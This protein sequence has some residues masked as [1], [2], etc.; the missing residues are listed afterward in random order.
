MVVGPAGP[1]TRSQPA[2]LYHA[3]ARR[4]TGEFAQADAACLAPSCARRLPIDFIFAS[5]FNS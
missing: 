2:A 4:G 3:R 5:A 1:S